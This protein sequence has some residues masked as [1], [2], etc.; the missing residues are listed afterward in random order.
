MRVLALEEKAVFDAIVAQSK[1]G[2]VIGDIFKYILMSS[3]IIL[4][5]FYICKDTKDFCNYRNYYVN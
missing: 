5:S 2:K 3:M 4:L 1:S